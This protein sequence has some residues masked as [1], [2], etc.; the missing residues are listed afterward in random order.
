MQEPKLSSCPL[1]LLQLRHLQL[2]LEAHHAACCIFILSFCQQGSTIFELRLN[3]VHPTH[4][5]VPRGRTK[6]RHT[7]KLG[8]FLLHRCHVLHIK[9]DVFCPEVSRFSFPNLFP[10]I[11]FLGFRAT[12]LLLPS[13]QPIEDAHGS[14]VSRSWRTQSSQRHQERCHFRCF[15]EAFV[16]PCFLLQW[17]RHT[18]ASMQA[19]QR[20]PGA[21][22]T[23]H[24][25]RV[26]LESSFSASHQS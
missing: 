18:H 6:L 24:W 19:L 7:A 11:S 26:C 2:S 10:Q 17:V 5:N 4:A 22:L 16:A 1:H 23:T 8:S 9:L 3:E 25:L 12:A 13:M 21:L 20:D 14:G 15:S